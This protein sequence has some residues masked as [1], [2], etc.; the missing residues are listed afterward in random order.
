MGGGRWAVGGGRWAVGG[1]RWAAGGGRRAVGGGRRAAGGGRRAAGGEKV[2]S[3]F[4]AGRRGAQRDAG[5][6][7]PFVTGGGGARVH[8]VSD[9]SGFTQEVDTY[10]LAG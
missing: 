5:A 7:E 3:R 10:G 4:C 6:D 1:G 8:L 2:S 9:H